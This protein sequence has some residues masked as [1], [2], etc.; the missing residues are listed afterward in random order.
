MP[1]RPWQ[2]RQCAPG[3]HKADTFYTAHLC[4]GTAGV[5]GLS[6]S[7][8]VAPEGQPPWA[9]VFP[10]KWLIAASLQKIAD[11]RINAVVIL[12]AGVFQWTSL[13]A[14]LRGHVQKHLQLRY[15]DG[16]YRLG[17]QAPPQWRENPAHLS[18]VA[19]KVQFN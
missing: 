5:D 4:P 14:G 9:W 16:L 1:T 18:F 2:L 7:W 17:S 19:Y 15:Y 8:A 10:P 11:E 3:E 12:P 6:H 13:L